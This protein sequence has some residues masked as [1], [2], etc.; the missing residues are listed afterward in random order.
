MLSKLL[1]DLVGAGRF[2]RPTPCAQGSEIGSRRSIGF[3]EFLMVTQ[4]GESA[5]AQRASSSDGMD[6]IGFGH[7]FG[8]VKKQRR[9]LSLDYTSIPCYR[10][11]K[12][13]P[14]WPVL[15]LPTPAVTADRHTAAPAAGERCRRPRDRVYS[16][17]SG[18]QTICAPPMPSAGTGTV[19]HRPCLV[20]GLMDST[21]RYSL[22]ALLTFPETQ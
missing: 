10:R 20:S 6:W 12:I 2:E 14:L 3:R 11:D 15:A 8:T 21:T 7:S 19:E 22:S 4:S 13:A 18:D 16:L 5:F 1:E 9:G 17:P